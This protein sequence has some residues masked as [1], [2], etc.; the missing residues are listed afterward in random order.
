MEVFFLSGKCRQYSTLDFLQA[1]I[2]FDKNNLKKMESKTRGSFQKSPKSFLFACDASI[3]QSIK[4][5]NVRTFYLSFAP[6]F[7]TTWRHM[8]KFLLPWCLQR[9]PVRQGGGIFFETPV[10]TTYPVNLIRTTCDP[11][12]DANTF[13]V[14]ADVSPSLKTLQNPSHP[15]HRPET[16]INHNRNQLTIRFI[17]M[18]FLSEK[19]APLNP[20]VDR[21]IIRFLLQKKH[22]GD[23]HPNTPVWD[24][25][26]YE[27]VDSP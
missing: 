7:W 25:P 26:K 12:R 19:M 8:L 21:L 4:H 5:I 20:L 23:R 1:D 18:F 11:L 13:F 9:H 6:S 17:S 24:T 15:I 22:L 2:S 16:A 3:L 27:K 10:L 14:F